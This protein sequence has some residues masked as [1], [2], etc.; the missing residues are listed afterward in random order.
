MTHTPRLIAAANRRM[1]RLADAAEATPGTSFGMEVV[2]TV[3]AD[4]DTDAIEARLAESGIPVM[5]LDEWAATHAPDWLAGLEVESGA[6]HV[7]R[8]EHPTRSA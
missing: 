4:P 5:G 3:P 7:S 2:E 1:M 8:R 6:P